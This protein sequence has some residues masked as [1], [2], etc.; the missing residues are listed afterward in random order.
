MPAEA[1]PYSRAAGAYGNTASTTDPRMLE[2]QV[3]LKAAQKLEDIANRLKN[4]ENVD[5]RDVGDV[6]D[7]NQKLWTLFVSDA[8]DP[9]HPLPQEI[10]NNIA[11]LGLFIFKRTV[12]VRANPEA[13]KMQILINI[14]R[15]IAAGLMKQ[16]PGMGVLPSPQQAK[17]GDSGSTDS[18][19]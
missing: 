8:S 10:K 12:E 9:G 15:N 17:P 2:G 7:Y 16:P 18:I 19:I 6:L 1:N 4:G 3:L 11:S 13:V 5:F 14:N